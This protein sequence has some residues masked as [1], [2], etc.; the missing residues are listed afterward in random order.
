MVILD[1][2]FMK[3]LVIFFLSA[4]FSLSALYILAEALQKSWQ[5]RLPGSA[6]ARYYLASTPEVLVKMFPL[7]ALAGTVI[8]LYN[9]NK[10]SELIAMLSSGYS[11]LRISLITL[12]VSIGICLLGLLITDKIIPLCAIV[13]N[14]I[15]Q[16]ENSR[17]PDFQ[18]E[19]KKDRIWYRSGNSIYSI[20]GFHANSRTL[21]GIDLYN[22]SKNWHLE[23]KIFAPTSVFEPKVGWMASEATIT[24]LKD[25][26]TPPEI[27][28]KKE[29]PLPITEK[30]EDFAQT[31]KQVETLSLHKRF[32]YIQRNKKLGIPVSGEAT[33][34]HVALANIFSPIV[35][36]LLG[37]PFAQVGRRTSNFSKS[38]SIILGITVFYMIGG[39]LL[40]TLGE[41]GKL[42]PWIAGW[43][44]NFLFLIMAGILVVRPRKS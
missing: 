25:R 36:A 7:A 27:F 17:K 29:F 40:Q 20:R 3:L 11:W 18:S 24:H 32:E 42:A 43:A 33:R 35:L 10:K 14:D 1:R 23:E 21:L 5:G 44:A 13:K 37:I 41:S 15:S 2:F 26:N 19:V 39:S 31:N 34:Y 4:S 9:L 16:L 6:I 30:P 38:L 28:K 22:F 8:A 12:L